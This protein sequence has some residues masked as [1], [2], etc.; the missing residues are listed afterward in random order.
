MT[1]LYF[2]RHA[3]PDMSWTEPATRP[4]TELGLS[5]RAAV[6]SALSQFK[7]DAFL[8]SPYKRSYDTIA[9]CAEAF[10]ME[11]KTDERLIEQ[12]QGENPVPFREIQWADF[13][14]CEPGGEPL[15]EVQVRNISALNDMLREYRNKSVVIGTHGKALGTILNYFDDSF[16]FAGY[17][18]IRLCMPY[19]LRLDFD[20]S[21][22]V[23]R[24]EL[25]CIERGYV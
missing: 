15:G 18:R 25:L 10:G 22:L 17:N 24:E 12:V 8:S 14:L 2:V 7:I 23:S 1:H 9:P 3:Q 13:S 20:G 6:T 5:D 11:I 4:L 16:R 19:I 21:E